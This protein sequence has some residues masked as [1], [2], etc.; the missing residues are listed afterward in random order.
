MRFAFRFRHCLN[1]PCCCFFKPAVVQQKFCSRLCK[2]Q[3]KHQRDRFTPRYRAR[4]RRKDR[5]RQPIRRDYHRL[6]ADQGLKYRLLMGSTSRGD[7][8]M[9]YR[10]LMEGST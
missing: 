9:R 5:K 10:M 3:S 1:S 6:R 4:Q 7:D 2:R 8:A